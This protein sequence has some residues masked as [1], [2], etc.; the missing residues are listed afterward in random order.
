MSDAARV[1]FEI[2]AVPFIIAGGGHG[3]ATLIDVRKPTF[4]TPTVEGVRESMAGSPVRLRILAGRGD[5]AR[6]SMWTA[7]LGFNLSHSLGAVVFGALMLALA[8]H[9][10]GFVARSGFVMPAA[11]GVGICYLALSLR[12]WF[13]APT[14]AIAIG[15]AGFVAAYALG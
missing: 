9:D 15:L 5:T 2:G 11:I 10:F 12:F 3:I 6:P 1:L 14:V 7:W 8:A 13:W 4:F